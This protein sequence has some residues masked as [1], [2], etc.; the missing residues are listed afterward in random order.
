[1][2]IQVQLGRI[3][4][5][6]RSLTQAELQISGHLEESHMS[7][8]LSAQPIIEG[9]LVKTNVLSGMLN[10]PYTAEGVEPYTGAY[11]VTP[12]S[13]DQTLSTNSKL[14][15]DDV[16]VFKIPYFETSNTDGTTVYIG[17]QI[18]GNQ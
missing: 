2:D 17:G 18:N 13:I 8:F 10:V 7:A 4:E 14:M 5:Q 11:E 3:V 15:T 6:T 1:M 9:Q 12:K 16:T